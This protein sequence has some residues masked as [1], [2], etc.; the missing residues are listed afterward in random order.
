MTVMDIAGRVLNHRHARPQ[1]PRWRGQTSPLWAV[2]PAST[3][4][5]SRP[6]CCRNPTSARPPAWWWTPPPWNAWWWSWPAGGWTGTGSPSSLPRPGNTDVGEKA[7]AS[8][9]IPE[10]AKPEAGAMD[11]G[12]EGHVPAPACWGWWGRP[13]RSRQTWT[14]Q[15]S[16]S[17][18]PCRTLCSCCGRWC[19][20]FGCVFWK[21]SLKLEGGKK[22]LKSFYMKLRIYKTNQN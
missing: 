19:C 5:G 8:G 13:T 21:H 14:A 3:S 11:L 22:E 2:G 16:S 12:R 9:G 1:L 4:G 17:C 10:A 20:P 7:K 18:I 6:A 15:S